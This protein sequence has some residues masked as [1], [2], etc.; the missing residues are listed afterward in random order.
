MPLLNNARST[1]KSERVRCQLSEQISITTVEIRYTDLTFGLFRHS[2]SERLSLAPSDRRKEPS[3]ASVS[4]NVYG[5]QK[6]T[7][8]VTHTARDLDG[9]LLICSERDAHYCSLHWTPF[10]VI[11]QWGV[12]ATV[13]SLARPVE[14]RD[15]DPQCIPMNVRRKLEAGLCFSN[16]TLCS[17]LFLSSKCE[18]LNVR[19]V[20]I[21]PK[22]ELFTV[23]RHAWRKNRVNCA[24]LTGNS[25]DLR[26]V[27]FSRLSHR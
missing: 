26:P 25:A 18:F 10:P 19:Y 16:K 17:Y 23:W 1:L 20:S 6:L 3:I 2:T 27:L 13:S 14:F 8:V 24:V 9:Y 21:H 7:K 15:T 4:P 22:T 5:V 12:S 11:Y